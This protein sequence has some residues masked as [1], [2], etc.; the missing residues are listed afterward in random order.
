MGLDVTKIRCPDCGLDAQGNV[1]QRCDRSTLTWSLAV[2]C[3]NC[4]YRSEMD[5]VGVL[6]EPFRASV[7]ASKGLFSLVLDEVENRSALLLML[8][9]T[10]S[11]SLAESKKLLEEKPSVLYQGTEVEA[12]CVQA[13][14]GSS[15]K[16][17]IERLLQSH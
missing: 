17:R 3:P 13:S 14:I 2:F 4:G 5:D 6:P 16:S 15:C 11:L 12:K 1:G 7:I 10:L 9:R 8:K